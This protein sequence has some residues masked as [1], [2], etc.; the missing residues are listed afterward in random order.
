M[1]LFGG[2]KPAVKKGD[3]VY[4]WTT[5]SEI[6]KKA[7]CGGAVTTFLKHALETKMWTRCWRYSGTGH[8]RCR[9][10]ADHRPEGSQEHGRVAPLRHAAPLQGRGQAPEGCQGQEDR[11]DREGVRPDGHPR[12][13]QEERH[14]PGQ[15]SPDRVNC[16]GTVS[17]VKAMKMI[18]EIY[19]VDP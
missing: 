5:D 12:A 4:A 8:L 15:P 16:G 19:G 3:M 17:P 14:Q 7:E 1:A 18:Q 9:P 11:H 6:A 2:G 10:D 13:G